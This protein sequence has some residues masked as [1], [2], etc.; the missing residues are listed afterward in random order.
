MVLDL[1]LSKVDLTKYSLLFILRMCHFSRSI[2]NRTNK[3]YISH[4][5]KR[6]TRETGSKYG[7]EIQNLRQNKANQIQMHKIPIILVKF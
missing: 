6:D 3:L 7:G 1:W 5:T 2:K 4:G